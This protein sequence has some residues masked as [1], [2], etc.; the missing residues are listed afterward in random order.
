MKEKFKVFAL[1]VFEI[2]AC[3]VGARCLSKCLFY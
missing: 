2:E 3:T 1:S